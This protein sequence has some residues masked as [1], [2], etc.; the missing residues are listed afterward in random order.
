MASHET[1]VRSLYSAV[2][3]GT[4]ADDAGRYFH[5]EAEQVEY[6]S[7][8]RPA[9]GSRDLAGIIEGARLGRGVIRDQRYDLHAV[10][11][12]GERLAVQFTWTATLSADVAGMSAG[13]ALVAHV[14]AF[15]E[16]RNGLIVRQSS[17]DCY[18]PLP[19]P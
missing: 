19:V 4:I 15:Y 5:P 8:L 2:A 7:L 10:V 12:D 3:D 6:P 18:E 11:D 17:Y 9:G 13:S 16:F 1:L 14:A